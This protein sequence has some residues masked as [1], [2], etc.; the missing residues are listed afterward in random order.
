VLRTCVICAALAASTHARAGGI[1]ISSG[2]PRAIGRAG[3]GTVGDDGGGALL[4][5]PA[6]IARRDGARGQLG[7]A[8]VDDEIAWRG[9][10]DEPFVRNQAAGALAPLG[11]VFAAVG[12][13]IIGAGVMTASVSNRA[14]RRPGSLPPDSYEDQF[15]FRY[16][17]FTGAVRRDTVALGVARR[18]GD[19]VAIGLSV[20]A[21][22]IALIERRRL[23][24]GFGGRD[25][26][27]SPK[28]DIELGFDGVDRFVPSAVAGVFI[29][30]DREPFEFGASV[31]VSA[32]AR[33]AAEV[34][35]PE[36]TGG[37]IVSRSRPS[38]RL[39]VRQPI[40]A[41]LGGRYLH[42]RYIVELGADLWVAQP[43]AETAV[44]T[45]A[46]TTVVDPSRAEAEL[47]RVPS[48]VSLRTHGA[49]R[50][51]VDAELIGGFLWAT[52]GYA[53][54]IGGVARDRQSPTFGDL[55]GHT[56]ALGIEG[57]AGGFTFTL[58]WSRTWSISHQSDSELRLDNPFQAGDRAV[59]SGVYDG[60]I[61]QLG[62]LVDAELD[63]AR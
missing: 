9:T 25:M 10:T 15:E 17:G 20:A 45:L 5:N 2:S 55:G 43:A 62:I 36:N 21:S 18:L 32:A 3:T 52:A 33:I 34:D 49:V 19:S 58:G 11:A 44:W 28:Q 37:P 8:F 14:V 6:A 60:S 23:W 48:R 40:A 56:L 42:E 12:P 27:G 61:D 41:R 53:Y 50:G 30:P 24:A 39:L 51:A 38:A 13:W 35:S 29:A 47:R 46:G 26:I 4:V 31:G 63:A 7:L 1:V 22:R 59:P 57:T 16:A 54:T